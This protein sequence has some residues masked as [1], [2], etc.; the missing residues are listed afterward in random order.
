MFENT[1]TFKHCS[2]HFFALKTATQTDINDI[3]NPLNFNK[4][5]QMSLKVSTSSKAKL[6]LEACKLIKI[7]KFF[8]IRYI[9]TY[10]SRIMFLLFV[11]T[12]R[13]TTIDKIQNTIIK[14]LDKKFS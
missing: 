9:Y 4:T 8:Q 3:L 14:I 10:F 12:V 13:S 2:S 11:M 5:S 1:I 6:R 7:R